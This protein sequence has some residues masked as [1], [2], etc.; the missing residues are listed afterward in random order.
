MRHKSATPPSTRAGSPATA[1]KGHWSSVGVTGTAVAEPARGNVRVV[2]ALRST[3][4]LRRVLVASH[5]PSGTCSSRWS[6]PARD[7]WERGTVAYVR[8]CPSPTDEPPFVRFA[9]CHLGASTAQQQPAAEPAL[10]HDG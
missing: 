7:R 10:A 3:T 6:R 8:C 2:C 1:R 9:V 4:P 5:D